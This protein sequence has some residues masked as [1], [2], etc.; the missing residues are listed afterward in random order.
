MHTA[1]WV[2]KTETAIAL[3]ERGVDIASKDN[4]GRTPLHVACRNGQTA[5]ALALISRGAD[6]AALSNTGLSALHTACWFGQTETAIA[7]IDL[8]V[9]IAS[10]DRDGHT[11]LHVACQNGH[12]ATALALLDRGADHRV[13]DNV[14]LPALHT[15]C[16]F[17][18]TETALAIIER[19]AGIASRDRHGR[20]PLHSA[21]QGGQTATALAL[22]DRGADHCALDNE[23]MPALHAACCLHKTETAI[24]LIG[25]GANISSKDRDGNTPLLLYLASI[26][27]SRPLKQD[28]VRVFIES[29]A[30]VGATGLLSAVV[31]TGNVSTL[32]LVMENGAIILGPVFRVSRGMRNALKKRGFDIVLDC[33]RPDLGNVIRHFIKA[34][35]V[36]EPIDADVA[37]CALA[38]VFGDSSKKLF[39][40][41]LRCERRISS[42]LA[43][44]ATEEH[45]RQRTH[46]SSFFFPGWRKKALR[47][48]C[49]NSVFISSKI[50]AWAVAHREEAKWSGGFGSDIPSLIAGIGSD[51]RV[52]FSAS[53]TD[54]VD[55]W[56]ECC[57]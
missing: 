17:G 57:Q 33:Q 52:V 7:L 4:Y 41:V 53:N 56:M 6:L 55:E 3:I 5:T 28:F 10:K 19:G 44:E 30:D 20:T 18:N 15:A 39:S 54:A 21:C 38:W 50:S 32:Q 35:H 27:H 46:A 42:D 9:D 48:A 13:L 12:T 45:E 25:R 11:P 26:G 37:R 43:A 2:G 51:Q 14:G 47:S 49:A 8:H 34:R 1:C 24:A 29:G 22:L 16:W 40:K 36:K 23:G 31:K